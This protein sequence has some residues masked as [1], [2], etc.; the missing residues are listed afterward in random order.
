LGINPPEKAL[1]SP[2]TKRTRKTKDPL[3]ADAHAATAAPAPAVEDKQ[4]SLPFVMPGPSIDV[5]ALAAAVEQNLNY[6]KLASLV[7]EQIATRLGR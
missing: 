3:G 7:V 1:P 6:D 2:E 5:T 4:M